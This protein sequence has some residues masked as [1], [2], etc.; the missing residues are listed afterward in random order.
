MAITP[1][2]WLEAAIHHTLCNKLGDKRVQI[3]LLIF[4]VMNEIVMRGN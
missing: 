4:K 2:I 1:K 3:S